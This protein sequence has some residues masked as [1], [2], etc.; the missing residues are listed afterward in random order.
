MSTQQQ[1]AREEERVFFLWTLLTLWAVA[2]SYVL[3][4]LFMLTVAYLRE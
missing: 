2:G 1:R 4:V 3:T